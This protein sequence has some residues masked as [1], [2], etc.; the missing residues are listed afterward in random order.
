MNLIRHAHSMCALVAILLGG[1]ALVQAVAPADNSSLIGPANQILPGGMILV[2][3]LEKPAT[4]QKLEEKD[5]GGY[6]LVYFK[7]QTHSAYFAVSRD[8]YTF[9]DINNGNPV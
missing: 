2:D 8:G 1:T 5:F 6:L 4:A 7:D 3:K 9:T